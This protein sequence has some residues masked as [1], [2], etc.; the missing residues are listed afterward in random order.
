MEFNFY[1][2]EVVE[3]IGSKIVKEFKIDFEEDNMLNI[4]QKMGFELKNNYLS[5]NTSSIIYYNSENKVPDFNTALGIVINKRFYDLN[6]DDFENIVILRDAIRFFL[7]TE[8]DEPR[9]SI[10]VRKVYEEEMAYK[11]A[12]NLLNKI[13]ELKNSN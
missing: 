8:I 10:N 7:N 13:T 9:T 11:V 3:Q 1:E 12:E 6:A 2:N 5:E 4:L